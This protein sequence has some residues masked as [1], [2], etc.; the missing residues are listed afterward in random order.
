[1]KIYEVG[2]AVRDQYLGIKTKDV[3]FAVEAES[4][5]AM[6]QWLIDRQFEIF[7]ETPE[8]LTIRARPPRGSTLAERTNGADFVLC[9]KDSPGSDGRRPD[10]V[11]A[12]TIYD[13][14]ARRD[15]TVNAIAVNVNTG[16]VI[17]P[18]NG[19]DDIDSKTL[20]FVGNPFTRI[21]EDGLRVIRGF[22]FMITRSLTAETVTGAA[23]RSGFASTQLERIAKERIKAELEYMFKFDTIAS[24]QL[25]ASLP[26]HL[27]RTI[28]RP[29][30]RLTSTMKGA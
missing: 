7:V 15:F 23:L 14:L 6:K 19:L 1:M 20:R 21:E 8:Y 17:D 28:F 9:R 16:E 27:Q 18:H 4:Y 29:G 5:D 2:G 10:Y 30:I 26:D 12:G 25:V 13:D 11:E 3:D 22:R 24:L